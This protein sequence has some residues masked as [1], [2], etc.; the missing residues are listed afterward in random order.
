M[1]HIRILVSAIL[2][3]FLLSIVC[4]PA[5]AAT[6]TVIN[7]LDG[8]AGSLRAALASAGSGDTIVFA[9]GV[10]G[11][12]ALL[13]T[14]SITQP[15]TIQGPG[16]ANLTL[17]GQASVQ[18][19][20]ISSAGNLTLSG[21]T[22]ANGKTAGFGAGINIA[23][24]GVLT[25]SNCAFVGNEAGNGGG[26]A[27]QTGGVL[28]VD[29]C[30]FENN[31]TTGVGG[32]ALITSG[33]ATVSNSTFVGNHAPINRGAVNIQPGATL[34]LINSTLFNNSS[35]GLGGAMSSL[36]TVTIINSTFAANHGSSG[37]ALATGNSS[38]T[39]NN[40]VF[41]DNVA[42]GS[43]GALNIQRRHP[44]REQQRVLQQHGQWHTRRPDRLWHVE[45]HCRHRRAAGGARQ[46]RR[47]DADHAAA[48]RRGGHLRGIRCAA[49]EWPDPGSARL[50]AHLSGELRGCRCGADYADGRSGTGLV[51]AVAGP[52]R[53]LVRDVRHP[54]PAICDSITVE[55][56]G[57]RGRHRRAFPLSISLDRARARRVV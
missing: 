17:D 2:F 14:L 19:M 35:G 44:H 5:G 1:P 49:A 33:S 20:A 30:T 6:L 28:S 21:V 48:A 15:V 45:L 34:T 39:I 54:P 55:I 25:V 8:G 31:N 9:P 41:A 13:S 27:N 46:L 40:S 24:G 38:V 3:L 52:A 23:G 12:I 51:D 56:G 37:S 10:T 53:R 18:V 47:S 11:S 4:A 29:A 43:P 57:K 16:V 26:I 22:I 42:T 32:G 50:S 7:T 36:G